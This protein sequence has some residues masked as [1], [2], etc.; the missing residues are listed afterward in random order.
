[1]LASVCNKDKKRSRC[2]GVTGVVACPA[3]GKQYARCADHDGQRGAARS[4]RSHF[5]LICDNVPIGAQV[6]ALCGGRF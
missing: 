1:M 4:L 5:A 2:Q 3:C 6:N